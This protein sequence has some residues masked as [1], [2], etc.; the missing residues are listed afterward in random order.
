MISSTVSVRAATGYR[1]VPMRP[2]TTAVVIILLLLIIVA[3]L[4][5]GLPLFN[6]ET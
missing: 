4:V 5:L 2:A 3:F 1:P 6:P